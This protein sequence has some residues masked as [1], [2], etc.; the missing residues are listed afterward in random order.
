MSNRFRD[1]LT[2]AN[3]MA[4]IAVFIALGGTSVATTIQLTRDS[5]RSSHVRDG[6]LTHK[7][8]RDG[9]LTSEDLRQNTVRGED[10]GKDAIDRYNLADRA[11]GPEKLDLN[12]IG[13]DHVVDA[14]LSG[15]DLADGS[16]EGDDVKN[17]SLDA[18]D[19]KD[20]VLSAEFRGSPA[21]GDLDGTYPNPTLRSGAVGL[22]A[23]SQ[24]L[25]DPAAADPG[26]RTLGSGAD[27]AAPGNDPRIPT[28][29]E[30]DALAGTT[31]TP[32]GGNRFVTEAD[33]RLSNARTPA[34]SAGGDLTGSY[35][36]PGLAGSSVGSAEVADASLRLGDLAV[37]VSSFSLTPTSI[38]ANSCAGLQA[39]LSGIFDVQAGDVLEVY[40]PMD[41]S[42]N[43]IGV[44]WTSG[45]QDGDEIVLLAA[46]NNTTAAQSVGGTARFMILR[47]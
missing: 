47:P 1:R 10:I 35:P 27:Q 13:G 25:V 2:Y 3:V 26:L 34:G 28:Q 24:S 33:V 17:N 12:S 43:G 19:F 45:A 32:G 46:C 22:G 9:T 42:D 8:I 14:T 30:N 31:G 23:I 7:D 5:V 21:G 44:Q 36:N 38:P 39:D 18:R 40:P 6:A 11:V 29:A 20:G 4:T 41:G 16:I 15:R 37:F